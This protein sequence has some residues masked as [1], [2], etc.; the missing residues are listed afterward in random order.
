V[1]TPAFLFQHRTSIDFAAGSL[2]RLGEHLAALPA[3]RVLLVS[4]TG[5]EQAELVDRAAA[6]V[7]AAGI[8]VARY[9]DVSPNPRD[10]ECRAAADA[11]LDAGAD[12]I[13]G[14]GGGSV[15]D[16]T[17]AAAALV[18]NGGSVKD[19][20]DPRRL[21]SAPLP[22]ICVPTTAGTG[23]EVTFVA[24]ITD[25]REHY[26]MTLL[27]P[28]LAPDVAVLDPELTLSLPPSITAATGMDALTQAIEAYTGRAST[29]ITDPLAL[30]AA[31]L[32]AAHLERAVTQPATTS[33]RAA[34]CCSASLL[35]GM[36]FGNSDVG[37]V[38][39]HGRDAS[40]VVYDTPHGVAC[41]V[42]LPHVFEFDIP[43]D[44][45]RHAAVARALGVPGDGRSDEE[46]A[47]EAGR[48]RRS[49]A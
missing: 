20:E 36:A 40:A 1:T 45:A 11:A 42:F 12:A 15:M 29:P 37:S 6:H 30:H 35:A 7:D 19:W 41:A 25:E 9:L 23:S 22:T 4:D 47:S 3:R 26:K 39:S 13:V 49:A 34:G 46:L 16:T 33:R 18:T 27:D 21:D 2:A 28:R 5:L 17:K 44:P 32:L 10:A 31:G 14:L 8:T 43:A 24:V 38:H 48:R